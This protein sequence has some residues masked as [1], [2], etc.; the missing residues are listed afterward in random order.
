MGKTVEINIDKLMFQ[1]FNEKALSLYD[2]FYADLRNQFLIDKQ[3]GIS[4]QETLKRLEGQYKNMT[5]LFGTLNSQ[6]KKELSETL[7]T[8]YQYSSNNY[9]ADA[10]GLYEWVLEPTAEHCDSCLY[11]AG[12]G[13]LSINEFPVPGFQSLHGENN[14]E[15]YCFT[16][17]NYADVRNIQ[18]AYRSEYIGELCTLTTLGG[19][20]ITGTPNHPILTPNGFIPLKVLNNGDEILCC[21]LGNGVNIGNPDINYIPTTVKEVF[22]SLSLNGCCL[23]RVG[24]SEDFYGD[25]RE[26]GEV[27]IIL[28]KSEL[29]NNLDTEFFEHRDK[30][31]FIGSLSRKSRLESNSFFNK[32]GIGTKSVPQSDVGRTSELASFGK[33][34]VFHSQHRRIG[35]S[36]FV[37]SIHSKNS[38]DNT[39]CTIETSCNTLDRFTELKP[40]NDFFAGQE[41]TS[42][43][44]LS[45]RVFIDKVATTERRHTDLI[46]VYTFQTVSGIY[47]I[48]GI[49]A[50]NCKCTLSKVE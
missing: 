15:H 3:L 23:R 46:H 39:S 40:T 11:Q 42:C 28:S 48:N 45:N 2:T 50:S 44:E 37:D 36:T 20:K 14:C 13:A 17:E 26:N 7:N 29:W 16:A 10:K 6:L 38:N 35:A 21:I 1:V 34:K 5:G 4:P 22:D 12:R 24:A 27:N 30:K 25:G 9:G 47:N 19:Q 8:T 32:L 41:M 49:I 18:K 43:T 33:S 31:N